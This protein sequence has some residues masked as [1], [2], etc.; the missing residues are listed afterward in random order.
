MN[1]KTIRSKARAGGII[2]RLAQDAASKVPPPAA[3][4]PRRATRI[5][6]VRLPDV[7]LERPLQKG[8]VRSLVLVEASKRCRRAKDGAA[9]VE[10]LQ[11]AFPDFS[12]K[13]H[14]QKLCA[15]GHLLVVG[16]GT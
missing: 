5:A 3:P 14:I 6:R 4:A 2:E 13:G 15:T 11:E 16:E 9:S 12:V 10:R 7:P 8:S 1:E